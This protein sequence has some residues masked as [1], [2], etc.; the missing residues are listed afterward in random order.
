M[1]EAVEIR[2]L[3]PATFFPQIDSTL[4]LVSWTKVKIDQ[5]LRA[6]KNILT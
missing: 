3:Y 4:I 5:R 2:P 1:N 6:C